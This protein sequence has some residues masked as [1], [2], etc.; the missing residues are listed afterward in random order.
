M[1][2][3]I[4]FEVIFPGFVVSEEIRPD[5]L[6]NL[7]NDAWFG[8]SPGPRQHLAAA[9]MRAVEEGIPLLR[10]ANTGIS[11]GFDPYGRL[12]GSLKIG[13]I[14]FVDIQ[15]PQALPST[16]YAKWREIPLL[17]G[18]FVISII[19]IWLDQKSRLRQ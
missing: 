10:S 3:L 15:V 5:I 1:Q 2:T 18:L 6:V 13:E 12:L 8:D 19:A 4:C 14:G 17:V 7:T 9:Q 11:A 16:F